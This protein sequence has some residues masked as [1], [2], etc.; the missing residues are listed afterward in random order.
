MRHHFLVAGVAATGLFA[1]VAVGVAAPPVDW[2]AVHPT[3]AAA[4][5]DTH[6]FP[7]LNAPAPALS[8]CDITNHAIDLADFHGQ[9]IVLQFGSLTDPIFRLHAAG[10]EKLAHDFSG[11]ATVAI[12]YQQE[13]HPAH[14]AAA[15]DINDDAGF[16]ISAPKSEADRMAAAA[17]LPARLKISQQKTWVDDWSNTTR[18]RFG[19]MPNMTFIIDS[20]GNLAA[21]YAWMDEKKIRGALSDL[22]AN[23]PI[24]A[25]HAGP[26]FNTT[27]A[28]AYTD[29]NGNG[30]RGQGAAIY[31]IDNLNLNDQQRDAIFPP[32]LDLIA[33]LRDLKGADQPAANKA[34]GKKPGQ[35]QDKNQNQNQN[36]DGFDR[37]KA[38]A[39]LRDDAQKLKAALQANLS[40]ADAQKVLDAFNQGPGRFL[41]MGGPANL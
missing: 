14:T 20:A 25:D 18:H 17:S 3:V 1:G 32:L 34:A 22:L 2:T 37:Q 13:A 7:P 40:A 29:P 5:P 35:A 36:G 8:V 19:N 16:S 30:R 15:L 6:S 26:A 31:A 24:A 4:K 10:A 27:G 12:I 21:A 23:K 33:G 39:A 38:F 11:K 41:F 28:I 9:P